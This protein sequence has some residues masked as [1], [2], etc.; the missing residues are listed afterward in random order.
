[1][2]DGM[3]MKKLMENWWSGKMI[4]KMINGRMIIMETKWWNDDA[5]MAE[6][7][8]DDGDGDKIKVK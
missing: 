4:N 1:M 3:I 6:W 5:I 2:I 7:W 8:N